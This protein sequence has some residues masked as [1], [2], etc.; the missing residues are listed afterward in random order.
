MRKADCNIE[1]HWSVDNSSDIEFVKWR[2]VDA[3]PTQ[4]RSMHGRQY[5]GV[6]KEDFIRHTPQAFESV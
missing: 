5:S 1:S 3:E 6:F 2:Q 4:P